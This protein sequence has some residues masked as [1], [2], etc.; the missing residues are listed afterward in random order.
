MC[1][2]IT[3]SK[4]GGIKRRNRGRQARPR[5]FWVRRGRITAWRMNV[6]KNN[7]IH[8]RRLEG[9]VLDE[10]SRS[11]FSLAEEL[12]RAIEFWSVV[13][14]FSCERAKTIQKSNVWTRSFGKLRKIYPFPNKNR[15]VWTGPDDERITEVRFAIFCLMLVHYRGSKSTN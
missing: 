7:L 1:K 10:Y 13:I 14:A 12:Q 6:E 4:I 9:E 8:P 5:R 2:L 11:S 3:V 15:Y